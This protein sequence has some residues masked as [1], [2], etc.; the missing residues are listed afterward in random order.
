MYGKGNNYLKIGI[1]K[2]AL[3]FPAE[4]GKLSILFFDMGNCLLGYFKVFHTPT[5]YCIGVVSKP[6]ITPL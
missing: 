3:S 5:A 6:P 2:G 4:G 1:G